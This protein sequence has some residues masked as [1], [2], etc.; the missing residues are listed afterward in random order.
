[1]FLA[2]GEKNTGDDTSDMVLASDLSGV[3]ETSILSFRLFIKKDKKKSS[4]A[5]NLF[6]SQNPMATPVQQVQSSL[7]KVYLLLL[8]H[9]E[10]Y[11]F[12]DYFTKSNSMELSITSRAKPCVTCNLH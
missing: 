6:G 4:G 9:F 2:S 3:I 1:M 12:R 8:Y 10:L 7:D 11:P 5:R